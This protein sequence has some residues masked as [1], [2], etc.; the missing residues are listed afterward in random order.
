MAD[1]KRPLWPLLTAALIGLPVL[2]VASFGP[3]CWVSSKLSIADPI[4]DFAYY[5]CVW[6]VVDG[7]E[8][9]GETIRWWGERFGATQLST[10]ACAR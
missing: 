4:I 9:I 8:P 1:H 7:P 3:A 10:A 6:L 5:P 2:Y